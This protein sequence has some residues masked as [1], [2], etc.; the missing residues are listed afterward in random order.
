MNIRCYD[1][2]GRTVD[3]YTVVYMDQPE[4]K[5]GCFACVA[6]SAYPF[7]PQGFGQHCA[8]KPGRHLGK[9]IEFEDL[10]ADCQKLVKQDLDEVPE[11][12]LAVTR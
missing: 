1:N 6:M 9:W 3:R 10:P 2:G 5:P 7:H 4:S 8:A 11:G 12:C